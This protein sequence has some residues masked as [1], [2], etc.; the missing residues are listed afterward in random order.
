MSTACG[1]ARG[2]GKVDEADDQEGA[3]IAGHRPDEDVNAPTTDARRHHDPEVRGCASDNYA[4]VHPEV[5]AD[6]SL[7]NGGHQVAASNR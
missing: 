3:T 5:L 4:G 6:L 2:N 1:Y 7:A